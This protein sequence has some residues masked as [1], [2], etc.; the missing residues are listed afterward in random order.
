MFYICSELEKVYN[1]NKNCDD[2]KNKKQIRLF[3]VIPLR[4]NIISKNITIDSC[5]LINNFLDKS[6]KTNDNINK[7]KEHIVNS[8]I[9][10]FQNNKSIL[11]DTKAFKIDAVKIINKFNGK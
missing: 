6:L 5:G 8:T 10:N 2:V 4:N 1:E 11:L 9:I 7:E 3:N